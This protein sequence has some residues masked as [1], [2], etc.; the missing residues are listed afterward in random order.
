MNTARKLYPGSAYV[1]VG[2]NR[3]RPSEAEGI[4]NENWPKTN[5]ST[6]SLEQVDKRRVAELELES[7]LKE[8]FVQHVAY[9]LRTPLTNIIGFSQLM[10]NP[11]VGELSGTQKR[12]LGHILASASTVLGV[13]NDILDNAV[14]TRGALVE[15][16]ITKWLKSDL[17]KLSHINDSSNLGPITSYKS[18]TVGK[19]VI[20]SANVYNSKVDKNYVMRLINNFDDERFNEFIAHN[21][22]F[23]DGFEGGPQLAS[24]R[25]ETKGGAAVQFAEASSPASV[26]PVAPPQWKDRPPGRGT[27]PVQWILDHY[28]DQ[29]GDASTWS[30]GGLDRVA[31]R[32]ADRD[33][34]QALATHVRRNT[35]DS[36]PAGLRSIWP[37]E[38]P[39]ERLDR[40]L[41]EH[42][43]HHPSDAYH[44]VKGDRA[45]ADRL[46]QA[47][48]H[49]L[50]N[51]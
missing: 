22:H 8:D 14:A 43:I 18:E 40:E 21:H 1:S 5:S 37:D 46:Y 45:L 47:A 10:L 23:L 6:H 15:I 24:E 17:I 33:L 34:Y 28:G 27:N 20:T 26:A 39:R 50:S 19:F 49:R 35:K 36:L 16:D 25:G 38:K 4:A 13:I 29:S 30:P 12:Y 3:I 44:A 32:R 42:G 48:L 9:E 11:S 2:G 31:L 51:S 7:R 41:R